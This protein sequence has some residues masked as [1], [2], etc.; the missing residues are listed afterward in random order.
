MKR[1][2]IEIWEQ[3]KGTV[4]HFIT[5]LGTTGT[6]TGV[7]R[8]LRECNASIRAVDVQ[9][10]LPLHGIEGLKH[11]PTA[12]VPGIYDASLADEHLT[13]DTESSLLMT[14][15]LAKEEGLFVGP[16]SGAN[17][18]AAVELARR[19]I[20]GVGSCDDLMRWRRKVSQRE[21]AITRAFDRSLEP[22]I[23]KS[24][25]V[26]LQLAR[27]HEAVQFRYRSRHPSQ[28]HLH[29]QTALKR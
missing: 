1:R 14:Q 21:P 4:T 29:P 11:L 25:T 27:A 7:T 20:T 2:E 28:T 24:L 13:V 22:R 26:R 3:T 12:H 23:C 15:R 18:F 6:F 16:S 9:P 17:V 8:R 10:D 19:V 5:G